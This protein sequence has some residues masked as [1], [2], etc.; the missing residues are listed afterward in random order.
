MPVHVHRMSYGVY[1][2]I[3]GSG[4]TR[5][6]TTLR[7]SGRLWSG[8]V[9]FSFVPKRTLCLCMLMDDFPIRTI[10]CW[11]ILILPT[12]DFP[13]IVLFIRVSEGLLTFKSLFYDSRTSS[14]SRSGFR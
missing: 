13:I 7:D 5:F 2:S 9:L 8:S 10:L 4:E 6:K 3:D 11:L 12:R 1:T 14:T